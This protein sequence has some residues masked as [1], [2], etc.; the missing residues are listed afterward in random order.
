MDFK[1]GDRF[2]QVTKSGESIYYMVGKLHPD[3]VDRI[4]LRRVDSS[5]EF[6]VSSPELRGWLQDGTLSRAVVVKTTRKEH[7]NGKE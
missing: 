6:S 1:V 2:V 5:Y 4:W 7:K 3:S